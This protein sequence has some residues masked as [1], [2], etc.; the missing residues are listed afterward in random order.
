MKIKNTYLHHINATVIYG[1]VFIAG[2]LVLAMSPGNKDSMPDKA[3][4][5]NKKFPSQ[6]NIIFFMADDFGYELPTYTGGQSYSTPNL[7]FMAA[8]GIQFTN[9]YSHPDGYPS[10]LATQTGK[11]N[12][13]NYTIWGSLPAGEKTIGNMLHDAGYATCFVGKWN[14]DGGDSTIH[15]AGYDNYR[16]FLPFATNDN[17]SEFRH[18]YIDPHLYQDGGFLPS[19]QTQSR[20]SEDMYVDYLSD[21]IDKNGSQPFFAFYAMNLP[22]NPYTPS[23][24][25]PAYQGFDPDTAV[26]ND[27]KYFPGMVAYLDKTIGKVIK[28][29]EVNGI[30]Q[31]TVIMFC[32]DN[33]TAKTIKSK[34]NGSFMNGGKNLTTKI[35]THTPLEVYWPGVIAPGQISNTLM[36]YTDFLP[37]L[38][39]I[40]GIPVP[41]NYGTLDGTSFY[42]NLVGIAGT[43][44]TWVYA[45]WDNSPNDTKPPIRYVTDAIYKLYKDT[46]GIEKFYRVINDVNEKRPI[47]DSNLKPNEIIIKQNFETQIDGIHK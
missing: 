20:Y 46:A 19:S 29:L 39:G 36:D 13:R 4:K 22:R 7:D 25:D 26:T 44:R 33:A 37:T 27:E 30:A 43:D 31:N 41:S 47:A 2:I 3:K 11:Y 18:Q 34:Y 8:N 21:F 45:Y 15:R 38:A 24:D 28:K 17:D 1:A 16:V 9:A 32:A 14:M 5:V 6:P 42:D 12:I 10:R 35:G 23:P 40:A